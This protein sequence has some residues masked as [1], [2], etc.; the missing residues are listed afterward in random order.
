MSPSVFYFPAMNSM[1]TEEP[2]LVCMNIGQKYRPCVLSIFSRR[3]TF[4]SKDDFGFHW[5]DKQA[6]V[7]SLA[8]V[9]LRN[10]VASTFSINPPATLIFDFPTTKAIASYIASTLQERSRDNQPQVRQKMH[11]RLSW[12]FYLRP[13]RLMRGHIRHV[14]RHFEMRNNIIDCQP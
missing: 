8:A 3:L 9:E 1:A 5:F 14:Q 12:K 13:F 2:I 7:D 10:S 4:P 6:G 11:H